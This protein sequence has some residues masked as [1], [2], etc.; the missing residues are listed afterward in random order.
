[1]RHA[2]HKCDQMRHGEDYDQKAQEKQGRG[3]QQ[4]R[5][6]DIAGPALE[7]KKCNDAEKPDKCSKQCNVKFQRNS[8]SPIAWKPG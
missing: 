2:G 4:E 1:M 5:L 8:S 3:G 6:T 7:P